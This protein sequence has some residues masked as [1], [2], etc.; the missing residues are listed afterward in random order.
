MKKTNES[1]VQAIGV[2]DSGLGGISVL[3]ELVELMPN[4]SYIYYGDSYYAPYGAKSKEEIIERCIQI[5]DYFVSKQ[6]KAIVIACNTATSAAVNVLRD[7]YKSLPI[8]GMEPALKPAA[9]DKKNN[10][11]VVMA[12][13]LTLNEEKFNN[14]MKKYSD[15]NN[16]I[17]MPCPELVDIV[18]NDML[19]DTA[20]I[21]K[22]LNKY[23]SDINISELDSVVL[24]CTHFVFFKEHLKKMLDKRTN[25]IDGNK[26][27][28]KHLKEVLECDGKLNSLT[29]AFENG[30]ITFLNSH[31]NDKYIELSKKL[32]NLQ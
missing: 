31:K 1:N 21:A 14:L 16:I 12:T 27:T 26:G 2:F 18:E 6:V 10:N 17:K 9:H 23:Y 4:E 7:K 8:I 30:Q 15:T 22:T 20:L 19:N 11:I 24:G 29:Q 13:S 25:I 32:F 28:A 3:N 5:C